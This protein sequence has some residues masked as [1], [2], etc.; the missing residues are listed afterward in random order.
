MF[1]SE[2]VYKPQLLVITPEN[3]NFS[4][5]AV[6]LY[7]PTDSHLDL[8]DYKIVLEMTDYSTQEYQLAGVIASG[9]AFV[10]CSEDSH[11]IQEG[12]A[13]LVLTDFDLSDVSIIKLFHSA[14][15]IDLFGHSGPS[16]P[17]HLI[18][19]NRIK[20][21]SYLATLRIGVGSFPGINIIRSELVKIGQTSEFKT[22]DVFAF[23]TWNPGNYTS[24]GIH[25]STCKVVN[26]GWY[27][28]DPWATTANLELQFIE[29][30]NPVVPHTFTPKLTEALPA[31]IHYITEFLLPYDYFATP[32]QFSSLKKCNEADLDYE[33]NWSFPWA[34]TGHNINIIKH[35]I[36]EAPP[37][38]EGVELG[39][40]K[41]GIVNPNNMP[42]Q[43]SISYSKIY[44]LVF[45]CQMSPIDDLSDNLGISVLPTIL[46]NNP[47]IQVEVD[48]NIKIKKVRIL[49]LDSPSATISAQQF[50]SNA[51]KI[52]LSE[53]PSGVIFLVFETDTKIV[54]K[55][56]V[57]M[58]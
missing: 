26:L 6:E 38:I 29:T 55:K 30:V 56:I 35:V 49:S 19:I 37:N 53:H 57:K 45:D 22:S 20:D 27:G 33:L 13:D 4:D 46:V 44:F 52:D 47:Q 48:E 34:T 16:T 21:E 51:M 36:C 25:N 23:W 28:T 15:L 7:N 42:V 14:A 10:I 31:T 40:F 24:L 43:V 11:I 32:H 2:I 8:S 41:L 17:L 3:Q 54:V 18:D 5:Q 39:G 50:Y 12:L 9:A 1:I 58:Y